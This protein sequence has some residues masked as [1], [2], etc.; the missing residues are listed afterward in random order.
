[1]EL[2]IQELDKKQTICL[3]M[4]V[5]DEAHII[6]KTLQNILDN[7]P[8][9]YWVVSDT[10]STDNTKDII[11]TFFNDKNIPGEIFDDKWQDFGHNRTLALEHAY[12]KTDYLLIF[13]AD[14]SF[15]GEFVLPEKLDKDTYH[16]KFGDCGGVF[17]YNR[18]LLIN[19]RKKFSFNGV[20]HEFLVSPPNVTSSIIKGN[21]FISSG[22]NGARNND[23][24]KY[25]KDAT[26]LSAAYEKEKDESL[27]DRYA[28]YCAQSYKDANNKEKAIEWYKRTLT[29][30]NWVQEKYYASLTIGHLYKALGDTEKA[31]HYWIK[32][33]QYDMHRI[34]GIVLACQEYLKQ[35]VHYMVMIL[36]ENFKNYKK[37]IGNM[38]SKLFLD[39]SKYNYGLEIHASVAAAYSHK[40][41]LGYT[42]CRDII[43]NCND[44]N[45]ILLAINNMVF[46]LKHFVPA[47]SYKLFIIITDIF[48]STKKI[49]DN[50]SKVWEFIFDKI[51]PILTVKKQ[52]SLKNKDNPKIIITFTTCKRYDLFTQT[53]N[54]LINHWVDYKDIDYWFCVDDNSS[55]E[56]RTK[57]R[58]TYPWIDYYMK[59]S[60][61][62]GH[63]KSMNLIWKKLKK[64]EPTYWIHMEDDF[65]FHK[66]LNY[67]EKG[68]EG[69]KKFKDKNVRQV[70]FNRNYGEVIK[71]YNIG[72]HLPLDDDF[73]LH[74]HHKIQTN[75]PNC[76][77]W[78]H[79]SFRP[80]II[81]VSTI[82]ELGDYNTPNQFFEMDYA[83]RWVEA[84]YK[85]AFFNMIT[86]RH[87]GKLTSEKN[88]RNKLI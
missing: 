86:N 14:D 38:S 80:S 77:Y 5:K 18:P 87:I 49:S 51:R 67:I 78:P 66:K 7:I 22:K 3:N 6:A 75:I 32:S 33:S 31:L 25:K 27:K 28:F 79:Y 17:V 57:M 83:Q 45:L 21:Y 11:K 42:I 82:L 62:K 71:D 26:I 63:R 37:T 46:Y 23:P 43:I 50:Q 54:S 1:M 8:I 16:L 13:D 81:D 10:G 4:I 12:N 9:T 53:V 70:L 35:G 19:N 2:L 56:D 65:L 20:L 15:H 36:Y 30:N 44:K 47:F 73:C 34:E 69:L 39:K 29:R 24:Y 72:G 74:D 58:N 84:G 52:L 60:D 85:S 76:N 88:D 59:S 41:Q 40:P 48:H 55:D 68:I 61:E 64:L